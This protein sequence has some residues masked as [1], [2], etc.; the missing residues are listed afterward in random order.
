MDYKETY[1]P[2]SRFGGFS[3]IDGTIA[4]YLRVNALI[5][6]S[7]VI[8]DVGCGRGAYGEDLVKI[9]R[10]L[11]ILK[12]KCKKVIGIDVK[13]E[14]QKNPFVDEAHR[15]EG[16]HWPV[17][18]ESVDLCLSDSVLEHIED[19][20]IF[21]SECRRVIKPGGYLCIRT[22]NLLSYIGLLAKLIPNRFHA[23]VLGK[24][25]EERD[26]EDVFP[27]LYH[28]NTK[29]KI[30]SL[31]D[32]YGFDHFV[33]GYEAEPSYLS[34]SRFFYLLGV[35]HQRFAPSIFKPAIFAFARKKVRL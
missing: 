11:R 10:D 14:A 23:D 33:Y 22:P 30:R 27:T 25:K 20:E 29:R 34:F 15:I 32:K 28:C 4:F 3:D 8:L 2:E 21:F 16:G 6:P 5:E 18:D 9:R 19:P 13:K 31:L 35:I 7:F 17:K 12:G 1:Y 24:I 26:K